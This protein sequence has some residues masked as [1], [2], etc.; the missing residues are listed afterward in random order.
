MHFNYKSIN[1][2]NIEPEKIL[3]IRIM[4]RLNV[5]IVVNLKNRN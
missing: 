1:T 3:K 5:S 2:L 4:E